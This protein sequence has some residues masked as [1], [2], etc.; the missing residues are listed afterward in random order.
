MTEPLQAYTANE[1]RYY[2]MVTP[3]EACQKGPWV[4]VDPERL[5]T[6]GSQA[7]I[8]A[9]CKSCQAAQT[10][11]FRCDYPPQE[12]QHDPE[13]LN[14]TDAP[15]RII[16]LEQW[17]S[18]FYMLIEAGASAKTPA[19]TRLQGYRAALCMAE[20]LKFY[21][22]DELPPLSAFFDERTRTIFR[23]HPESFAR[24]KLRAL[25]DKLPALSTMSQRIARDQQKAER[26]WW[27]FWK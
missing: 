5:K 6:L 22:D 21:G 18:L 14:P 19:Q 8:E 26:R 15:S 3:C 9:T 12:G 24:Q 23:Q 16:D 27:Q 11:V 25:Q 10:F 17:L 20:A 13:C 4:P 1:A 2:L 7:T